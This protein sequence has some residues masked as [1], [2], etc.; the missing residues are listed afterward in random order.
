LQT[1]N[2]ED[3]L[4]KIIVGIEMETTQYRIEKFRQIT[5]TSKQI[6]YTLVTSNGLKPNQF[7]IGTVAKTIEAKD[8][9]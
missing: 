6:L 4:E 8:L 9:F 1:K 7:S 2:L 3:F 5:G